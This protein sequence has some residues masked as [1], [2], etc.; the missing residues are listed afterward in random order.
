MVWEVRI[1]RI[2]L[3]IIVLWSWGT[4]EGLSVYG[5]GIYYGTVVLGC[6]VIASNSCQ[7]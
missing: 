7:K 5:S 2:L 1:I 3:S 4:D 6:A